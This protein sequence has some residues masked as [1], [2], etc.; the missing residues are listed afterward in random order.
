MKLPSFLERRVGLTLGHLVT[1]LDRPENDNMRSFMFG[2][3]RFGPT[4]G[5]DQPHRL[6]QFI[7]QMAHETMRFRYDEEIWDGRGA[8]AGYD[9]RTDLGNTPERDG[10]GYLYRG[11]TGVMI[12]GRANYSAFN[13]WARRIDPNA[14]DFV[15]S[16]DAVNT[17]PWEGLA[18]L[19]FWDSRDLNK[20][21]DTGDIEMVTRRINGRLNGFADRLDLYDR[22][23]LVL[24][25]HRPNDVRGFQGVSDLLVDGISGPKTRAALHL[26]LVSGQKTT[27]TPATPEQ[28]LA[29]IFDLV[30]PFANTGPA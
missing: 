26:A 7:A 13:A 10:D 20:Y 15:A 30:K 28:I 4:I 22:S 11:R 24:L 2:L 9:V 5:M 16:P 25:G 12:T 21:A 19:W 29:R 23:A 1:I 8:Q 3:Q 6:A 27:P 18:P 14:P 17:D